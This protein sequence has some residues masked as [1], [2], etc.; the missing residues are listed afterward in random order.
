MLG[1]LT[2]SGVSA[3]PATS[4]YSDPSVV[5]VGSLA[6]AH[7]ESGNDGER[8]DY[9][10]PVVNMLMEQYGAFWQLFYFEY[11]LALLSLISISLSVYTKSKLFKNMVE[12]N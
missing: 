7:Q 4:P 10:E 11:P 12:V 2:D 1:N 5:L 6:S 8:L 3:D 9:G